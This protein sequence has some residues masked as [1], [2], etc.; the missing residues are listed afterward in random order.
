MSQPIQRSAAAEQ[1]CQGTTD[2]Q[3]GE[4]PYTNIRHRLL[5][6]QGNDHEIHVANDPY[7]TTPPYEVV[8]DR[9]QVLHGLEST[10]IAAFCSK[11]AD[12]FFAMEKPTRN[13]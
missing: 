1:P 13:P 5:T 6:R 8:D 2:T 9:G 3:I 4:K 10:Q 7:G 12:C 11:L